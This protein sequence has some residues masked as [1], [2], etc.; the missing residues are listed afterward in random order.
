MADSGEWDS[1]FTSIRRIY[2]VPGWPVTFYHSFIITAGNTVQISLFFSYQEKNPEPLLKQPYGQDKPSQKSL[3]AT[4]ERSRVR[5][6]T[7][8][9]SLEL[10]G[11]E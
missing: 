3:G 9:V 4:P 5:K 8:N 1:L 6:Q 11:E 10:V 7:Q 2:S